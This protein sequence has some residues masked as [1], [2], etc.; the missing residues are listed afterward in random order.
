M[1]N[2]KVINSNKC[3]SPTQSPDLSTIELVWAD[4]KAFVRSKCCRTT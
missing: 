4:L 3:E 2:V 1:W